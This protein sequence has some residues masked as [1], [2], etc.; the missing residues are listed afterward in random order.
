MPNA[1][2]L[3]ADDRPAAP[4]PCA[5]Q[6]KDCLLSV[7]GHLGVSLTAG[8]AVVAVFMTQGTGQVSYTVERM[9][10]VQSESAEEGY[11]I[12]SLAACMR[13]ARLASKSVAEGRHQT[14][15]LLL[16][17]SLADHGAPPGALL[18]VS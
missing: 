17:T 6:W 5:G 12:A 3:A 2:H 1:W 15:R 10:D 13:L 8:L 7:H 16:E 9:T 18:L 14:D 11:M 4:P